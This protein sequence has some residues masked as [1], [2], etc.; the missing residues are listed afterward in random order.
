MNNLS[1][2]ESISG[3]KNKDIEIK[4]QLLHDGKKINYI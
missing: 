3:S 1:S 2:M 4:E